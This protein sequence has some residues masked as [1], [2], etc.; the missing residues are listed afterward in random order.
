MISDYI[1]AVTPGQLAAELKALRVV[2]GS[3]SPGWPREWGRT[4]ARSRTSSAGS[5]QPG[6]DV[7]LAWLDACNGAMVIVDAE[8]AGDALLGLPEPH[9][10]V[11]R[12]ALTLD[13]DDAGA[14]SCGSR[15]SSA[16]CR[17]R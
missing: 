4:S 13:N 6:L 3:R 17:P 1:P 11:A 5:R 10:S 7:L 16:S 14:S 2:A 8:A 9:R 15:G 12:V